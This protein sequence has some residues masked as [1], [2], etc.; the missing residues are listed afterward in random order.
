LHERA[1]KRSR[2]KTSLAIIGNHWQSSNIH[3]NPEWLHWQVVDDFV[4]WGWMGIGFGYFLIR[5]KQTTSL[6]DLD[7]QAGVQ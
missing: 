1:F 3:L 6:S 5:Y 4:K 7:F 2:V